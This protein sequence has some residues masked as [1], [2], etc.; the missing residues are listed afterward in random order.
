[1]IWII[2]GIVVLI[3]GV[4]ILA[5]V[6]QSKLNSREEFLD[7]LA[8]FLE[9]KLEPMEGLD[10]S[11][12]LRF[13]FDGKEFVYEDIEEKRFKGKAHKA[14]LKIKAPGNLHLNFTEKK[15]TGNLRSEIFIAS[16]IP[17]QAQDEIN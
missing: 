15:R 11:Y 6:V 13:I 1:M 17:D 16:Q 4:L 3:L 7:K 14:Y 2:V 5:K 10:N 9:S 12:K 8:K